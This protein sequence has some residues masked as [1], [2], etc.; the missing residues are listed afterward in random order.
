LAYLIWVLRCEKVIQEK[1][2]PEGEIWARWHCVINKR[3]TIN[4]VTMTKIRRSSEFTK[5]VEETWKPALRT[6]MELP[7]NWLHYSEVLVGRTAWWARLLG[8]RT[9]CFEPHTTPNPG[10]CVK[11]FFPHTQISVWL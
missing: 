4:K 11:A 5:L 10:V 7:A 3:L 1:P 6:T 2:L 9:S 8:G